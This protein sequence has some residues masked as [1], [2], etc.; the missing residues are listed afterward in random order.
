MTRK[1]ECVV[2]IYTN[3]FVAGRRSQDQDAWVL[4]FRCRH[5]VLLL[6]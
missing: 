2:S 5:A 4:R 6:L 1:R 3:M